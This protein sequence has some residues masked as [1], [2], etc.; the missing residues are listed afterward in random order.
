MGGPS[1]DPTATPKQHR[2]QHKIDNTDNNTSSRS[3]V[4]CRRQQHGDHNEEPRS[5]NTSQTLR[6]NRPPV[7]RSERNVADP[8]PPID[9]QGCTDRHQLPTTCLHQEE[10]PNVEPIQDKKP[11]LDIRE[12]GR[13]RWPQQTL[14][15][16]VFS[17]FLQW[18]LISTNTLYTFTHLTALSIPYH[19]S[20][21]QNYIPP[22]LP[23]EIY[24]PSSPL[25][26][27]TPTNHNPPILPLSLQHYSTPLTH[28]LHP[29][30]SHPDPLPQA[31]RSPA[32]APPTQHNHTT[33]S[34]KTCTYQQST[35]QSDTTQKSHPTIPIS[36]PLRR[37]CRP[38]TPPP[39]RPPDP[40]APPSSPT[41]HTR[42]HTQVSKN[43]CTHH[44]EAPTNKNHKGSRILC[45]DLPP[46][47]APHRSATPST[48][49]NL[50]EDPRKVPNQDIL[51]RSAETT[52]HPKSR[53]P[54]TTQAYH[55][56]YLKGDPK[57]T[58]TKN[59][60]KRHPHPSTLTQT[61]TH[62]TNSLNERH[63]PTPKT[64]TTKM[65]TTANTQPNLATEQ[66]TTPHS[67]HDHLPSHES[68]QEKPTHHP[69]RVLQIPQQPSQSLISLSSP[70]LNPHISTTMAST[71][72]DMTK[73]THKTPTAGDARPEAEPRRK[74]RNTR[75]FGT[76][77]SG[78]LR[79]S[80]GSRQKEDVA[81]GCP[82]N[83]RRMKT[84][85][86]TD[87]GLRGATGAGS[88]GEGIAA[89]PLNSDGTRDRDNRGPGTRNSNGSR[90]RALIQ[91]Y[92]DE[93]EDIQQASQPALM[94]GKALTFHDLDID[95]QLEDVSPEHGGSSLQLSISND[96]FMAT[97]NQ[98]AILRLDTINLAERTP[99]TTTHK[100]SMNVATSDNQSAKRRRS[101]LG[102]IEANPDSHKSH[103]TRSKEAIPSI[104]IVSQMWMGFPIHEAVAVQKGVDTIREQRT[105]EDFAR[106]GTPPNEIIDFK[107]LRRA[108]PRVPQL[109]YPSERP[110]A[111]PGNH[112]H[113]TQI[114]RQE[115]VDPSTGLSEGFHVTIRFDF[116]FK[117]ILVGKKLEGHALRDL[118]TWPSHLAR[119][120]RTRWM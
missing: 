17:L 14:N 78:G 43:G 73:L 33:I 21:S 57:Q 117:S 50:H 109:L 69:H 53:R 113:F 65:A 59:A 97:P 16:R 115:K 58:T 8:T 98:A 119:H 91:D 112:L 25:F 63:S 111:V 31:E 90:R 3:E 30:N 77:S 5:T 71:L 9:N 99:T 116:G 88:V 80:S 62:I 66:H 56:S 76:E 27:P 101:E 51:E 23:S 36:L 120:T 29:V 40:Q 60:H 41:D 55:N 100:S 45:T 79:Q 52:R 12:E 4:D 74:T 93:D 61:T 32:P 86:G 103:N 92:S 84:G 54:P 47:T 38:L 22:K 81:R 28:I 75:S 94:K 24:P 34:I 35:T 82:S 20:H 67:A 37:R 6:S 104:D 114:P 108:F 105:N 118:S 10:G 44:Q 110:D 13:R 64:P 106:I 49:S 96:E 70:P 107:T 26:T 7:C 85:G 72:E 48:T 19:T 15:I 2:Q 39:K 11:N 46:A 102:G 87:D 89:T 83:R 95:M 42:I 68:N 18:V 1:E